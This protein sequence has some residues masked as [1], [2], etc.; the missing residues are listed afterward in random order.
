MK[1]TVFGTT[2]QA[3]VMVG[4]LAEYGHQVYWCQDPLEQRQPTPYH[5]Q[6]EILNLFLEKQIKTHFL[7]MVDFEHMP[8]DCDVF[9][10][11]FRPSEFELAASLLKKLALQA[12]IHPKMM[13]NGSTFGL[14]STEK[15]KQIFLNLLKMSISV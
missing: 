2:L 10:L 3:G 13:I 1:I 9:F 6:D 14:N 11:G 8:H 7:T 12:L 15:L 5:V 4:L